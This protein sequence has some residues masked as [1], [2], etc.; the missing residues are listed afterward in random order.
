[1]M[2]PAIRLVVS[3]LGYLATALQEPH[4]YRKIQ[5]AFSNNTVRIKR[6]HE[7]RHNQKD[8]PLMLWLQGG[9]G[10]SSLIG[11]LYENGPCLTDGPAKTKFN[12]YSWTEHFSMIYLDQPVGVGM[13]YLD[14]EHDGQGYPK[15]VEDSSLDIVAFIKLFYEAFPHLATSDLHLGGE[16]YAGR[17]V[18]ALASTILEYNEILSTAPLSTSTAQEGTIPLRSLM[19]GNPLIDPLTQLP[20]MYDVSCYEYRGYEPHLTPKECFA[21]LEA[22]DKL[23]PL[24]RACFRGGSDP[25]ICG[26]ANLMIDDPFENVWN[27]TRSLYDRRIRDCPAPDKCFADLPNVSAYLNANKVFEELLEVPA[28]TN[29]KVAA[30]EPSDE[31]TGKRFSE[32]GDIA[33]TSTNYLRHVLDFGRQGRKDLSSQRGPVTRPIDALIYVGVTDISCN[34]EGVFAALKEVEW[35]GRAPFRAV[36][37]KDLPL[38]TSRGASTGRVKMVPNLWMVELNEAGHMVP[39]DQPE[40]AL[41]LAKHWLYSIQQSGLSFKHEPMVDQQSVLEL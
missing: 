24:L 39:Y 41:D 15:G 5:S 20:T 13:S 28:Q 21:A 22:L 35:E 40:L 32:S 34:A 17:Y 23:E 33:M 25:L 31:A 19:I 29:H 8:A 10:A 4:S 18:P 7:A 6:Y 14:S 26:A 3:T 16:S 9:P 36:P 37:W 30:W 2:S 27:V 12:P 1:M 38:R 11:M